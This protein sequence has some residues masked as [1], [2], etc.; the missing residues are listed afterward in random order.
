MT[1]KAA[2]KFSTEVRE[3][4]IRLVLD[5]EAEHGSRWATVVSIASKIGCTALG[6]TG[7]GL[8]GSSQ[9]AVQYASLDAN[10]AGP[11]PRRL[12]GWMA[13]FGGYGWLDG[14]S[15]TSSVQT[16]TQGLAVGA[17]LSTPE[18]KCIGTPE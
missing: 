4:A 14:S 7:G 3:R 9:Q 13:G 2:N 16:T 5:Q 15:G 1:S 8:G 17:D 12:R 6:S 10:E 11:E 18:T